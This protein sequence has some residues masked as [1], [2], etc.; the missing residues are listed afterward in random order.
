MKLPIRSKDSKFGKWSPN[1]EGP[2][3]IKH[4]APGNAYILET[5]GEEE[6]FDRPTNGKY[7]KKYYPSVWINT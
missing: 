3:H 1:W 6:E 2:Y 4:C 7:L 5:L